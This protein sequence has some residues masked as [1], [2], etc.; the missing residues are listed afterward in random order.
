MNKEGMG[1]STALTWWRPCLTLNTN[2]LPSLT[3]SSS[4]RVGGVRCAP[5]S[6][7]FSVTSGSS[8]D[9]DYLGESTKGDFNLNLDYLNAF[10][11]LSLSL[12]L[13]FNFVSGLAH[14]VAS[15]YVIIIIL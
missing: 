1:S 4:V 15:R 5:P 10:R 3:S 7:A 6:E 13:S 9:V 2:Q 8:S 12:L 11:T 14:S